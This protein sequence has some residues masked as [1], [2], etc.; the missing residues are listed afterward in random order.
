MRP[1]LDGDQ[2]A[3]PRFEKSNRSKDM[4]SGAHFVRGR[5]LGK[6][7]LS[8]I[9]GNNGTSP[10]A[11][12]AP[13]QPSAAPPRV[14]PPI[15]NMDMPQSPNSDTGK[16]AAAKPD[17]AKSAPAETPVDP[18][19]PVGMKVENFL[20]KPALELSTGYDS[21]PA[22]TPGGRGSPV[23]VVAPELQVQSQFDRHEITA[24]LKTGYTDNTAAGTTSHPNVD[25]KVAGR[26]DVS[27]STHINAEARYVYDALLI[28]GTAQLPFF[29]T[30]GGTVGVT[31]N[32][33]RTDVS[34]NGSV[35]RTSFFNTAAANDQGVP[36][37]DR[38]YTQ[39]GG[40]ARVAYALIAGLSPFVD[41]AVDQRVHDLQIDI[42][43]FRRN[44]TGIIARA[45][46]ALNNLGTISGDVSVGYLARRTEDP[47]LPNVGG[48]V[49]DATLAW[50]ATAAT[51]VALLAR[52]QASETVIA[53]N[54]AILSRDAIVQVEHRFEPYL[55]GTVRAGFGFDQYVGLPRVDDRYSV[56][57]A[58]VYKLSRQLQLK[59]ELRQ[60]WT[61]SN[62]AVNNF[63]ASVGLIGVRLQ[64]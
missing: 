3:L 1:T 29:N 64:Y 22:R 51:S 34:V 47:L 18:Y 35:D 45:G 11:S 9:A 36:V 33:G 30:A 24:N 58:M 57:A 28:P 25:A 20:L 61:R 15:R 17:A 10:A 13:L 23:V 44:S 31:Q 38:N 7:E 21:N 27:D 62:Q 39:T 60:E 43:G 14:L 32:F 12:I 46:V 42:N 53:G 56:A 48:M 16:P 2:R 63:A 55:I 6:L 4:A 54:S 59:A 49:L 40:Q 52:T 41:V 37:Q 19:Q 50:Q 8:R 5:L 26:Y